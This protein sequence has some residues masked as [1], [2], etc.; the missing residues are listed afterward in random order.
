MSTIMLCDT[1]TFQNYARTSRPDQLP[2]HLTVFSWQRCKLSYY[3]R[4]YRELFF[5]FRFKLQIHTHLYSF[6]SGL[7]TAT[8]AECTYVG[9]ILDLHIYE[10]VSA[11]TTESI[12]CCSYIQT[13]VMEDVIF[14]HV[15]YCWKA[16]IDYWLAHLYRLLSVLLYMYM[17]D[18]GYCF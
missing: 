17:K 5:H 3:E 18:G 11:A 8:L 2:C 10:K 1:D 14:L 16:N 12:C 6:I 15:V 13:I 7:I 4:Q 9:P